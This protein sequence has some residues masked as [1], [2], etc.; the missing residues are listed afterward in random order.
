MPLTYGTEQ[1]RRFIRALGI[2][3]RVLMLGER[4]YSHRAEKS[5]RR[6]TKKGHHSPQKDG[7]GRATLQKEKF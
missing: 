1:Q 5:Y 4:R 2:L 7:N 3:H 6:K